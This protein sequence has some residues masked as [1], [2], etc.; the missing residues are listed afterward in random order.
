MEN[1]ICPELFG[2]IYQYIN[3]NGDI[4]RLSSTCKSARTLFWDCYSINPY[5]ESLLVNLIKH[6]RIDIA[7][8]ILY[9]FT[10]PLHISLMTAIDKKYY[11]LAKEI[12]HMTSKDITY[13]T[14]VVDYDDLLNDIIKLNSNE[15]Y[16]FFRNKK[17]MYLPENIICDMQMIF[18]LNNK[19]YDKFRLLSKYFDAAHICSNILTK[20]DGCTFELLCEKMKESIESD[21]FN[22]S[23]RDCLIWV[24]END[25]KSLDRLI[26]ILLVLLERD[27]K[28][29]LQTTLIYRWRAESM[30]YYP[31]EKMKY[32]LNVLCDNNLHQTVCSIF[33]KSICN[34]PELYEILLN[35]VI[36]INNKKLIDKLIQDYYSNKHGNYKVGIFRQYKS[37]TKNETEIKISNLIKNNMPET[38]RNN[39][40]NIITNPKQNVEYDNKLDYLEELQV[41][42]LMSKLIVSQEIMPY[43]TNAKKLQNIRDYVIYDKLTIIEMLV[44]YRQSLDQL[45]CSHKKLIDY[46][47]TISKDNSTKQHIKTLMDLKRKNK[48]YEE[49]FEQYT[50][51]LA[52]YVIAEKYIFNNIRL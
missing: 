10:D 32:I 43:L 30:Y 7:N 47:K 52:H 17:V 8:N 42:E 51:I 26:K 48:K 22:D 33:S 2:Y 37:N 3:N 46:R 39:I 15:R 21:S 6:D 18:F 4:V 23:C 16:D 19:Q 40:I 27:I 29:L 31:V 35:R 12:Y 24:L 45:Y 41:K 28:I 14:S 20:C 1:Y 34:I 13:L 25:I 44:L 9:R 38:T 50:N 11:D 5:N 36:L 49:C